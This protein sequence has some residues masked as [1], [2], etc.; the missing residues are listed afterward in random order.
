MN[1][2]LCLLIRKKMDNVKF[3][4]TSSIFDDLDPHVKPMDSST[5]SAMD[6]K[7]GNF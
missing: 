2:C 3:V 6:A 1:S 4:S 5:K 7:R